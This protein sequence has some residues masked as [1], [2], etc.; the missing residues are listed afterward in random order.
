MAHIKE[1]MLKFFERLNSTGK[2][3]DISLTLQE[4]IYQ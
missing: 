2:C 1:R 4:R 3:P